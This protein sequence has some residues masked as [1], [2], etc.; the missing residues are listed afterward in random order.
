MTKTSKDKVNAEFQRLQASYIGK[1]P[2]LAKTLECCWENFV[3]T[4]N[5]EILE[6]LRHH[7]HS[8]AGTAAILGIDQLSSLAHTLCNELKPPASELLNRPE[9]SEKIDERLTAIT[10]EIANGPVVAR[11]TLAKD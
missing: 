11:D 8:I 7:S 10:Q 9:Y 2:E 6:E 1:L 5:S 4:A 3:K